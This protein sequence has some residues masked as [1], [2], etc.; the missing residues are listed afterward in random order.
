MM[1]VRA[2]KLMILLYW[3]LLVTVC[4]SFAPRDQSSCVCLM[5]AKSRTLLSQRNRSRSFLASYVKPTSESATFAKVKTLLYPK[6]GDVVRYYDLDGG[7]V[8]GETLIGKVSFI[9]KDLGLENSWTI[10]INEMENLGDGYYADYS[11]RKRLSK[12]SLRDVTAVAPVAASFVRSEGAYKIP[13]SKA[14]RLPLVRQEAYDIDGYEGPF[15]GENAINLSVV[16][17][18]GIV[19]AELK[20]KLLRYVAL[21]GLAGILI[22]DLTKGTQ[23]AIIYGAGVIASL[24]YLV[25]LSLKTDTIAKENS[26]TGSNLSNLRFLMPIVLVS[27]IALYN[28]STGDENPIQ[29][30]SM[31]SLVTSEQFAAAMLGFLSYRL[32]LFGIQIQDAF[33]TISG[34]AVLP[35]SAGVALQLVR[36]EAANV[37]AFNSSPLNTD[38]LP[39]IFL[40][41]GPQATGRSELVR[42]LISAGD[43]KF[44]EPRRVDRT[45]DGVTFERLLQRD[46]FLSVDPTGRYGLT[47]DGILTAAED[48]GPDSVVVVDANVDVA[49]QLTKVGGLRLVG[50]WVGLSSMSEFESRL[51]SLINEGAITIPQDESRESVLRG[52][53]R[54]IVQEIEYGISCGVF[55][56]TILNENEDDSI[57]ELREAA[58]YCFK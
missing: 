46:E 34:E 36:S 44:L 3:A 11:G 58:M 51:D 23:D 18:D 1:T 25:F 22:A 48:G 52:R 16:A 41:S 12:K 54:D 55:E 37:S 33:Q 32:P 56:F 30:D 38:V 49:K 2:T 50:V 10:E 29:D 7:R 45:K 39:T 9:Q 17:Q 40:V 6:V 27:I 21:T 14:T 13:L 47:K 24:L 31:F 15:A 57:K 28:K 53:I 20:G 19:Y 42:K 4:R 43:G 26:K 5:S 8:Q 35:G